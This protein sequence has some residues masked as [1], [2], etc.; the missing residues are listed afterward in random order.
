MTGRAKPGVGTIKEL[1]ELLVSY[2]KQETV[3][4]LKSLGRYIGWGLA[5]SV[6][7]AFAGLFLSLGVLRLLQSETGSTFE[8][9]SF[10]SLVPYSLTLVVALLFIGA[11]GLGINRFRKSQ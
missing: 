11:I 8:G 5:G 4:P 2:A 3:Q 7:M 10:A 1:Q 9:R 6:C